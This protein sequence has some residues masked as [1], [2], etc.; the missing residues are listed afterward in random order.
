MN[1]NIHRREHLNASESEIKTAVTSALFLRL[2]NFS[3][4]LPWLSQAFFI[5]SC[6]RSLLYYSVQVT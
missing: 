3:T 2:Y 1:E 4:I 5:R 6:L